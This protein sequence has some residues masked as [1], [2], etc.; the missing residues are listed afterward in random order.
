MFNI[1]ANA[2][3]TATRTEPRH[4][5]TVGPRVPPVTTARRRRWWP[6]ARAA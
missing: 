6:W 1:Y 2:F 3:M 4:I 5:G